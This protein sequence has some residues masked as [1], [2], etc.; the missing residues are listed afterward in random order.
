VIKIAFNANFL[1]IFLSLTVCF[2]SFRFSYLLFPSYC[3][4]LFSSAFDCFALVK[5]SRCLGL[6]A[7]FLL[8][9]ALVG[10]RAEE[11]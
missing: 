8:L 1:A 10:C 6:L 9:V 11:L 2:F 7:A 3:A 4:F 5:M